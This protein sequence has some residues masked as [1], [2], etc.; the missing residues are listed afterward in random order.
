MSEGMT[1]FRKAQFW[2]GMI[3]LVFMILI[4]AYVKEINVVILAIPGLVMG[5]DFDKIINGK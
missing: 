3:L 2:A 1:G 5:I 4:H